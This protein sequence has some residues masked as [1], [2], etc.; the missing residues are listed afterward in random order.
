MVRAT[1]ARGLQCLGW[2]NALFVPNLAKAHPDSLS[3][4]PPLPSNCGKKLGPNFMGNSILRSGAAGLFCSALMLLTLTRIRRASHTEL[5]L[6]SFTYRTLLTELHIQNFTYRASH[7]ELYLQSFTYRTLLTEL[8]IQNFTY[9][10]SHTELYLQSFTHRASLTKLYWQCFIC[11]A[12]RTEL[13]SQ[14]YA[15]VDV[16]RSTTKW[17]DHDAVNEWQ[18]FLLLPHQT[19]FQRISWQSHLFLE[20][21][22]A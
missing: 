18:L 5:Y 8:H 22:F 10:A 15:S 1:F 9:R 14:S 13:A 12:S 19:W 2:N 6:Q 16:L 7:T 11:R 3:P 17:C 4:L 20:Q 21:S